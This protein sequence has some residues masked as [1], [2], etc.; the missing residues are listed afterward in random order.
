M[1]LKLKLPSLRV[2][3]RSTSGEV[4]HRLVPRGSGSQCEPSSSRTPTH[5]RSDEEFEG[6]DEA[7]GMMD[8]DD[9][10]YH[11][12][13]SDEPSLHH[14]AQKAATASWK[15]LRP[16][17]LK[18]VIEGNAMPPCTSCKICHTREATCR[19]LQCSANMYFCSEC[20]AEVHSRTNLF[21]TGEIWEVNIVYLYTVARLFVD[22]ANCIK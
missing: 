16:D 15:K 13:P 21:H 7:G 10:A 20:Y 2:V 14:I 22:I 3:Q 4:T 11:T 18:A 17:L 12:A 9:S 1:R 8:F 6:G 5:S 19:C